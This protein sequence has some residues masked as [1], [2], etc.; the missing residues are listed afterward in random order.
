MAPFFGMTRTYNPPA[1]LFTG[2]LI[3]ARSF[4][5][6][7]FYQP[8]DSVPLILEGT[9]RGLDYLHKEGLVHMELTLETLMVNR[10][11]SPCLRAKYQHT[12]AHTNAYTGRGKIY[13][14]LQT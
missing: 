13:F 11:L 6:N 5:S 3:S 12:H 10:C 8:Q 4:L 7:G 1:F 9:L 2:D 14:I